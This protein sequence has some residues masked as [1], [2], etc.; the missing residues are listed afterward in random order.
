[1]VPETEQIKLCMFYSRL[2]ERLREQGYSYEMDMYL[3]NC[4]GFTPGRCQDITSSSHRKKTQGF[5]FPIF[6]K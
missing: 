2:S 4:E 5:G 6:M 3:H 1:M